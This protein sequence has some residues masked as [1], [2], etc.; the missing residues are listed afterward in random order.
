MFLNTRSSR[1]LARIAL[2]ALCACNG[3]FGERV[4]E[5]FRRSVPAGQAALVRLEN[6]AGEV[7]IDGWTKPIVDVEATKYGRDAEELSDIAIDVR[8]EEGGVSIATRYAAG[9]HGGGVRYRI[10]IPADASVRIENVAGA[11]EIA[12]VRGNVDVGTQA[13][14]IS[15]NVG[16]VAGDRSVDLR[17]TT[18]A[19]TLTIAPG[20]NATVEANSTVGDFASDIPGMTERR[21]HIVGAR[22]AGTIGSGSARIRL[23]TTTGAIA[24][25]EG[26]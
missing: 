3:A 14:M 24:L 7:R 23:T 20:S 13:G 6:V 9:T 21:E 19:L 5:Q 18:G 12:G 17:A 15:A 16:Q 11:V 1:V 26:P 10:M 8:P 2:L 4:H 22:G 25:R